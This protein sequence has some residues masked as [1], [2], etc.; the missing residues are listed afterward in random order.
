MLLFCR[1][2]GKELAVN[3]DKT[4]AA[5]GGKPV[6]ATAFCRYCG[7]TTSAED[8]GCP[9]CGAAIKPIP[10][11]VRVLSKDLQ[12]LVRLGEIVNKVI[13]TTLISAYIWFAFPAI[14]ANPIKTAVSDIVL[15]S[16]GYTE[17]PVNAISA[18]P[19]V[20]PNPVDIGFPHRL[21]IGRAHV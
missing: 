12:R 8:L 18:V 6:K 19:S 5:C 11:K 17:F 4:C 21:E 13:I 14:V 7:H 3:P 15:Q 9:T 2:C 10:G 1:N 16:T 20:I